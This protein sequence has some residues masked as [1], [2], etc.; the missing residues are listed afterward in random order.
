MK[1]WPLMLP[2]A[3][4]F[5][6]NAEDLKPPVE[7]R[8]RGVQINEVT[9]SFRILKDGKIKHEGVVFS[10]EQFSTLAK[11]IYRSRPSARMSFM[12]DEGVSFSIEDPPLKTVKEIGFEDW[13]AFG[14]S[15]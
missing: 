14:A 3:L 15:F 4:L 8:L 10:L 11:S 5:T 13:V 12:A 7:K 6:L 1:T 2:F 9:F